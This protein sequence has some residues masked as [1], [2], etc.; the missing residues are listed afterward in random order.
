MYRGNSAS[1]VGDA[2]DLDAMPRPSPIPR[3]PRRTA[4]HIKMRPVSDVSWWTKLTS[5]LLVFIFSGPV[6]SW[7]EIHA[8]GDTKEYTNTTVVNMVAWLEHVGEI[9]EIAPG[10][11]GAPKRTGTIRAAPSSGGYQYRHRIAKRDIDSSTAEDR[12]IRWCL[13]RHVRNHWPNLDA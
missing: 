2:L 6:R 13:N 4:P 3:K 8:W 5:K 12:Y 9:A 1:D 7:A 10:L 11:W